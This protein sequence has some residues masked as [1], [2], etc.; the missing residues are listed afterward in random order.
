MQ[1]LVSVIIPLFDRAELICESIQSVLSQTYPHWELVVVDDGSTDGSDKVAMAYAEEDERIHFYCRNREPKGAPTCRNIGLE[2]SRGEYVIFLD[3]DDL[4]AP[5]CLEERIQNFQPD[6]SSD[7]LVFQQLSFKE[8]AG[9][10]QRMWNHLTKTEND[11]CRFLKGD[12]PW[13]T[14]SVIWKKESLLKI[15]GW[16]EGLLSWQDCDLHIRALCSEFTYKK[17]CDRLPDNFIRRNDKVANMSNDFLGVP[18]TLNRIS[19]LKEL[20][21]SHLIVYSSPEFK[22]STAIHIF[23]DFEQLASRLN[24]IY[25]C[26]YYPSVR[27]LLSGNTE[28]IK[29][30]L[31]L[32]LRSFIYQYRINRLPK[33][34]GFLKFIRARFLSALITSNASTKLTAS[35]PESDYKN[36]LVKLHVKKFSKA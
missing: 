21:T 3:S 11:L 22:S 35:L 6:S 26:R 36:L 29:S 16:K 23:Q 15:S 10:S 4:L 7:F 8:K 5:W 19:L 12:T 14:S 17:F 1:A 33:V 24:P 18:K 25:L 2:K 32:F 9:D 34:K 13:Q 28:Y 20:Y 31:F 30:F 27:F